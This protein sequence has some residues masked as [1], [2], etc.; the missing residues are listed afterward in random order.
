MS[1]RWPM[2]A[3]HHAPDLA[4]GLCQIWL[5][6]V[7]GLG[8]VRPPAG[9]A[10]AAASPGPVR[11]LRARRERAIWSARADLRREQ[12]HWI[13]RWAALRSANARRAAPARA[14][15]CQPAWLSAD[16]Q[17]SATARARIDGAI[18][19]AWLAGACALDLP[20][21]SQDRTG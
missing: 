20:A 8:V 14:G 6:M 11:G 4:H 2:T 5:M 19:L 13:T 21:K 12:R 16:I 10:A 17:P 3:V 15:R 7:R 9:H 1:R 18:S